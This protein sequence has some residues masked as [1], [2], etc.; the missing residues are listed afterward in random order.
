MAKL[1]DDMLRFIIDLDASG[2][3][4]KINTLTVDISKLERE[5]QSLHSILSQNEKEMQQ[6]AT[7]MERLEQRSMSNTKK[8]PLNAVFIGI[9]EGGG[10]EPPAF[11]K[12][13][14]ENYLNHYSLKNRAK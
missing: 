1:T 9:A 4:G 5:N 14:N 13:L 3:Q 11:W 8:M 10:F 7:Q 12:C 6:L 2:A